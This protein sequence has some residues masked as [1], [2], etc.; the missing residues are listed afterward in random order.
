MRD[1]VERLVADRAEQD[2]RDGKL[3]VLPWNPF[4]LPGWLGLDGPAVE[5]LDRLP[6]RGDPPRQFP[7]PSGLEMAQVRH[8]KSPAFC[9]ARLAA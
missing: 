3:L 5:A 4:A 9:P 6:D 8:K 2:R 7:P 1:N